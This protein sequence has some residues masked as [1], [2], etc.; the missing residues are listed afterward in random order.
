M[1][2]YFH[3][4]SW[5]LLIPSA[6]CSRLLFREFSH[7]TDSHKRHDLSKSRGTCNH[8]LVTC[9]PLLSA[10][11]LKCTQ[12]KRRHAL[13]TLCFISLRVQ[14]ITS[15]PVVHLA[16]LSILICRDDSCLCQS[17][18]IVI[19]MCSDSWTAKV[20]FVGRLKAR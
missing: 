5:L 10:P 18:Q 20:F 15:E 4:S 3:H 17:F 12:W 1:H 2:V 6:L 8:P 19:V 11:T 7:K 14:W 9:Q 13:Q 16:P